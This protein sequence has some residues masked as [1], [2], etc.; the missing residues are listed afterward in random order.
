MQKRME[1][2]YILSQM[3]IDPYQE[4]EA[5]SYSI[6]SLSKLKIQ[7]RED[8]IE[9]LSNLIK[10]KISQIHSF[11]KAGLIEPEGR[12][13][14]W[15][16]INLSLNSAN[17]CKKMWTQDDIYGHFLPQLLGVYADPY[18]DLLNFDEMTEKL[19]KEHC[20]FSDKEEYICG[21]VNN[22]I[23]EAKLKPK[24]V[25]ICCNRSWEWYIRKFPEHQNL[26]V[27]V[28]T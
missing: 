3:A 28:A 7:N 14:L 26:I 20:T 1:I 19:L 8:T 27:K 24:Q 23:C 15:Y 12:C 25:H 9:N 18:K 5:L 4:G 16:K 6:N 17:I 11:Y 22:I 13:N 2:F 21:L 10:L